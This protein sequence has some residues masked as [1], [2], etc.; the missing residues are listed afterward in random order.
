M[1]CAG[2]R[3]EKIERVQK[4]A[5]AIILGTKYSV[6]EDALDELGLEL[7]SDRRH[8]LSMKF[9]KNM[10]KD[11]KFLSLFPKGLTTRSGKEYFVIPECSTKR[12]RT[13]AI[14]TL[15]NLLNTE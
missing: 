11:P 7:L 14:P 15:I 1:E 8:S 6:Y 5:A 9:A 13:S 12:Y 4:I 2:Q 10:S 3:G